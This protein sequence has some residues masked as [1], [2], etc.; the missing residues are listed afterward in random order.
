MTGRGRQ[1]IGWRLASA[2]WLLAIAFRVA[3]ALLGFRRLESLIRC[4]NGAA[5]PAYLHR[6]A[7]AIRSPARRLPGANCLVQACT[8]CALIGWRGYE[9]VIRVGVREAEDGRMLAHAWLVS[10]DRIV[11]GG[12]VGSFESFRP[13][14][15]FG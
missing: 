10:G 13:I 15:D 1:Q 7:L 12:A 5:P 2:A 9:A 8:A 3:I 4:G 14:A 6:V 11:T